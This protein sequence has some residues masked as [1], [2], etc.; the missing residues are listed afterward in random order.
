MYGVEGTNVACSA[1]GATT[2]TTIYDEYER[3]SEVS[4]HDANDALVSRVAFSRDQDG[5][6]LVERMEFAGLRGLFSSTVDAD[7]PTDERASLMALLETM[8]DDPDV[9]ARDIRVR[10][11]RPPR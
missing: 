9:L 4:F 3:P 5:R 1:L 6:V 2:S 11:E 10:R 8:P 7:M